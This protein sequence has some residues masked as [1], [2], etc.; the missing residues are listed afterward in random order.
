M[1]ANESNWNE[2]KA[3]VSYTETDWTATIRTGANTIA[4]EPV[5]IRQ[6]DGECFVR[7]YGRYEVA[8]TVPGFVRY[9]RLDRKKYFDTALR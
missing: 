9:E 8:D 1:L 5:F 3:K 6:S 7:R 4:N 2:I